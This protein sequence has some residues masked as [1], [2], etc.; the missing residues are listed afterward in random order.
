MYEICMILL[1]IVNSCLHESNS[2]TK[3]KTAYSL[4]IICQSLDEN[5]FNFYLK[6]NFHWVLR[7]YIT[8]G[9]HHMT[10]TLIECKKNNLKDIFQ[11]SKLVLDTNNFELDWTNWHIDIQFEQSWWWLCHFQDLTQ[12]KDILQS[13]LIDGRLQ[14]VLGHN[15]AQL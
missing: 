1:F 2:C 10:L 3:W 4:G 9:S 7:S 11:S 12:I 13:D 8:F 6:F 14:P 5:W 15:F